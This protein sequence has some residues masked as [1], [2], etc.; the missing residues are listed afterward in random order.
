[1]T[2][3][4]DGFLFTPPPVG[5]PSD[6]LEPPTFCPDCGLPIPE[7]PRQGEH[8]GV[9]SWIVPDPPVGGCECERVCPSEEELR[10]WRPVPDDP[11]EEV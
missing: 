9:S 2:P 6:D 3:K 7:P 8:S 10:W 1:M 5:A 4:D 11:P